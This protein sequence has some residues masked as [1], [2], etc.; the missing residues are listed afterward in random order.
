MMIARPLG[1][2]ISF[3][4]WGSSADSTWMRAIDTFAGILSQELRP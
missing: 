1:R 4:G 3:A 2:A